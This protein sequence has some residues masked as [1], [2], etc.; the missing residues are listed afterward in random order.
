MEDLNQISTQGKDGFIHLYVAH[1]GFSRYLVFSYPLTIKSTQTFQKKQVSIEM[2][3]GKGVLRL[4]FAPIN[5]TINLYDGEIMQDREKITLDPPAIWGEAIK[6][7]SNSHLK[8]LLA[9]YL[10]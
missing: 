1:I 10:L 4:H 6:I 8:T 2:Q 3:G 7:K 5:T 9:E